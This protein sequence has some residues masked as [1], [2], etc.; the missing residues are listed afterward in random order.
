VY[1]LRFH[2]A[3]FIA[4]PAVSTA[5]FFI[6]VLQAVYSFRDK[7]QSYVLPYYRYKF[8]KSRWWCVGTHCTGWGTYHPARL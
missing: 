8:I 6:K 7:S 5:G 1:K 2:M 3:S 4:T